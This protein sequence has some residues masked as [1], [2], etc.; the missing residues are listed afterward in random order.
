[1]DSIQSIHEWATALFRLSAH[2]LSDTGGSSEGGYDS[3][4]LKTLLHLLTVPTEKRLSTDMTTLLDFFR[5]STVPRAEIL[6]LARR[7]LSMC[8]ILAKAAM[9]TDTRSRTVRGKPFTNIWK[10]FLRM[11]PT[12]FCLW[13]PISTNESMELLWNEMTFVSLTETGNATKRSHFLRQN[14]PPKLTMKTM[15]SCTE[16]SKEFV[17]VFGT[18]IRSNCHFYSKKVICPFT[19]E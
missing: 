1:M 17:A 12:N 13:Q 9:L 5:C 16:R 10:V 2:Y 19:L 6:F 14:R 11:M 7:Y 18:E 3:L 4:L 15:M 8:I